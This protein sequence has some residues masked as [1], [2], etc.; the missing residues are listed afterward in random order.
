MSENDVPSLSLD[1]VA[2]K[3]GYAITVL[4]CFKPMTTNLVRT[5]TLGDA[6]HLS[7]VLD[8][9]ALDGPFVLPSANYSIGMASGATVQ[10]KLGERKGTS[11]V[12][13]ITW[14][15]E[16]PAW[17]DSLRFTKGDSGRRYGI[18]VKGDGIY[19]YTGLIISI[20]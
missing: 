14:T 5:V 11:R 19:V 4:D 15:D 8:L 20:F 17:V 18:A 13:I 6:T 12:P 7:P 10:I 16:K 2:S 9:S 3:R 1:V